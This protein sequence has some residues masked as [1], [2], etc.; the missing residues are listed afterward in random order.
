[1]EV[2]KDEFRTLKKADSQFQRELI[3]SNYQFFTHANDSNLKRRLLDNL[4]LTTTQSGAKREALIN[5]VENSFDRFECLGFEGG[6]ERWYL[7]FREPLPFEIG[8]KARTVEG[9]LA[10]VNGD[11]CD[12]M[13]IVTLSKTGY[14]SVPVADKDG[15][16]LSQQWY[17]YEID[18]PVKAG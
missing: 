1:M 2:L 4:P 18:K 3:L 17:Q 6:N 10:P 15:S 12:G 7:A 16:G 13:K 14:Q 9:L 5:N 8:G 11:C